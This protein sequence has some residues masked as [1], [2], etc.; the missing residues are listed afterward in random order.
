MHV[1]QPL[2]RGGRLLVALFGVS[3]LLHL[4]RPRVFEGIIPAPL[5]R[6]RRALVHASGVVELVCAAGLVHPATR[7]TAG[8]ASAGLL[9]AVF[10]A[11]V[12]A[13]VSLGRRAARR[14]DAASWAGFAVSV[15]RLP[16]QWPL[17]RAA[18]RARDG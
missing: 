1:H 14:R 7:G 16:V 12:Q 10:P 11:N 6:Y 8:L 9:I 18:L 15:A 5:R 13:T 4:L 3:G 2:S 17:I